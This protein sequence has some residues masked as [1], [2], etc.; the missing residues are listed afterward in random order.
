MFQI[1]RRPPLRLSKKRINTLLQLEK[2]S[3][4]L[5]KEYELY[6]AN[7]LPEHEEERRNVA[8][9]ETATMDV[10]KTKKTYSPAVEKKNTQQTNKNGYVANKPFTFYILLALNQ[11]CIVFPRCLSFYRYF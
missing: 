11:G 6:G 9:D 7:K 2:K 3:H 5:I 1:Q 8:P 4:S 10:P